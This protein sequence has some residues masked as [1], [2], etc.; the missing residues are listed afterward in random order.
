M[1]PPREPP[2]LTSIVP[3]HFLELR[4]KEWR[5]RVVHGSPQVLKSLPV[6]QF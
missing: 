6:L 1:M 3:L 5:L 2:F 4:G